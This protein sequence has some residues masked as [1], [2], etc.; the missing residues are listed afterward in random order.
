MYED[1]RECSERDLLTNEEDKAINS[2][3]MVSVLWGAVRNLNERLNKLEYENA[4]LND[5]LQNYKQKE[6]ND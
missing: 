2:Y 4:L 5:E 6:G 1:V 3:G